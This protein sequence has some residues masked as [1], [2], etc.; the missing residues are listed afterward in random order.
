MAINRDELLNNLQKDGAY[1]NTGVTFKRTNPVPIEMYSIFGSLVDAEAYAKENPVAYVGQ[2]I[3]VVDENK[4]VAHYTIEDDN[5][6]LKELG[7]KLSSCEAIGDYSSAIGYNNISGAKAFEFDTNACISW[8]DVNCIGVN[9][10]VLDTLNEGRYYL[11]SSEGIDQI[12]SKTDADKSWETFSDDEKAKYVSKTDYINKVTDVYSMVLSGNWDFQGKI[13]DKNV[14]EKWVKVENY[15]R[16]TSTTHYLKDENGNNIA[17]RNTA[18]GTGS[19]FFI[20]A[21]PTI[22]TKVIGN[23]SNAFGWST[24][25]EGACAFSSGYNN[26][27]AGKYSF[28]AGRDNK[29]GYCSAVFGQQSEALGH[30]NFVSGVRA[31]SYAHYANAIGYNNTIQAQATYGNCLGTGLVVTDEAQTVVGKYNSAENSKG[32][33]FVVGAGTGTGG[34]GRNVLSLKPS[35]ELSITGGLNANGNAIIGGT[36]ETTS[37]ATIGGAVTATGNSKITGELEVTGQLMTQGKKVYKIPTP[38][39]LKNTQASMILGTRPLKDSAGTVTGYAESYF[40]VA[41]SGVTANAIV[42]RQADGNIAVGY[43]NKDNHAVNKKYFDDNKAA[44]VKET[45]IKLFDRD[46]FYEVQSTGTITVRLTCNSNDSAGDGNILDCYHDLEVFFDG[47]KTKTRLPLPKG[48]LIS[49]TGESKMGDTHYLYDNNDAVTI[50]FEDYDYSGDDEPDQLIWFA[51]F[52]PNGSETVNKTYR[53]ATSDH[54]LYADTS[55]SWFVYNSTCSENTEESQEVT[56][57]YTL[58]K[59]IYLEALE[60]L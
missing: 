15:I 7:A 26:I 5:G 37:G 8:A 54:V 25:A 40:S 58:A 18:F 50:Y 6:S 60:T 4:K 47:D 1:W 2:T 46:E 34:N 9:N 13:L 51:A 12:F 28:S 43:A 53:D 33:V 48:T 3:T 10:E 49:I 52:T 21:K 27:S 45:L 17:Y 56:L 41:A 24:K 42:Q 11:T 31:K 38:S 36:L 35:G 30:N 59:N 55:E 19:Y 32:C 44:G 39:D 22:G 29:A 14:S 57:T 20:P 23:G 16:P